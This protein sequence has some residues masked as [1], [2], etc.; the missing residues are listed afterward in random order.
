MENLWIAR[1]EDRKLWL[2]TSR[3]YI[4]RGQ[5]EYVYITGSRIRLD[6]D[7]TIGD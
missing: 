3:P 5:R 2:Y 4:P 1:D 6:S 7:K